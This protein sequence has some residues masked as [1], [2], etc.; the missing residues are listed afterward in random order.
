ML[1]WIMNREPVTSLAEIRLEQHLLG[2]D[3]KLNDYYQAFSTELLRLSAAIMGAFAWLVSDGWL[4]SRE[5]TLYGHLLPG[6]GYCLAGLV[7]VVLTAAL[8]LAHRYFSS[9]CLAH[10]IA[11]LR[12]SQV[13]ARVTESPSEDER[14]SRIDD[15][16]RKEKNALAIR[17]KACSWFLGLA[18]GSLGLGAALI[19]VALLLAFRAAA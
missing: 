7:L 16:M 1:H 6:Q 17:L 3:F 14:W 2:P 18:A 11:Y 10:Q 5:P 9:D 13:R 4:P 15:R 12:L 8:S 19:T